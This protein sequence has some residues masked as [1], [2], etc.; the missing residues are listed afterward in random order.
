M[1]MTSGSRSARQRFRAERQR[2][3]RLRGAARSLTFGLGPCLAAAS[4]LACSSVPGCQAASSAERL[5]PPEVRSEGGE[6]QS[7]VILL[8]PAEPLN[9][10]LILIDGLRDKM[11]W[12]GYERDIAPWLTRFEKR[13]VSYTRAYSISSAT[14]RSVGPLLAGRYPSEMYR[15]GFFFTVYGPENLFISEIAAQAGDLTLSAHSHAYFVEETGIA[16]GFTD[17]RRLP[18]TKLNNMDPDNV[19]SERM[20]RLAEEMLSDERIG[21]GSQRFFAYFH[22]MDPHAPYLPHEG[23]PSWG[24][25]PRD[26][27][28]EEVRFTDQW[29]GKLVDWIIEQ[30]FGDDTAIII[31]ADHGESFGRHNLYKHGYELWEDVIHVPLLIYAP[32]IDARRIDTPR[33]HIDLAPTILELLGLEPPEEMP[34]RSLVPELYG[35]RAKPRPVIADLPRDNLQDR[36]RALIRDDEKLIAFGDDRYFMLFD[37]AEDPEEMNDLARIQPER[38]LESIEA[39]RELSSTIQ[40]RE[41]TGYAELKGAPPGRKW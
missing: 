9:V 38:A 31:S 21:K 8:D 20:T 26:L 16:Q 5:D 12:L 30:P 15:N 7:P 28:D 6:S 24:D 27:Y 17:F 37:L 14:A 29:V 11:P 10:V 41:V 13:T 22:Y 4:M 1:R 25:E 36:R 2:A 32:G 35:L 18:G 23:G 19:T 34:G 33:S 40:E 3:P 39:Y